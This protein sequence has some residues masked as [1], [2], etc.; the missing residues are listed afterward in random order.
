LQLSSDLDIS[1]AH[2][3]KWWDDVVGYD[4]FGKDKKHGKIPGV[5]SKKFK[6]FCYDVLKLP[7]KF[8]G[9]KG[10]KKLTANKEA[11]QEWE[12]TCD[13]I[14]RPLLA[15]VRHY[16]S[17]LVF[18]STFADQELDYDRRWRCTNNAGLMVTFRWS[19]SED[20][21]GYGTNLQNIPKGDER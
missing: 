7:H 10:N 9:S 21:F 19:T 4:I 15:A 13:V 2:I 1:L 11:C 8:A 6:T 17:M 12:E 3:R 5:S 20:A 14:F 16:R 18:K